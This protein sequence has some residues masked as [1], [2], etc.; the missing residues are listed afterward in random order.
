MVCSVRG[1]QALVFRARVEG[2]SIHAGVSA[3]IGF[4]FNRT[5]GFSLRLEG[6]I[7][8]LI[9]GPKTISVFPDP[10]KKGHWHLQKHGIVEPQAKDAVAL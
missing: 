10:Y 7:K 5:F 2:F 8:R 3:N 6:P 4:S 1:L 9:L